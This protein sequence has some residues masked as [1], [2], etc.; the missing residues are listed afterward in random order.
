[1]RLGGAFEGKGAI[2]HGFDAP[3]RYQIERIGELRPGHT[4][5]GQDRDVAQEQLSGID[6]DEFAG[7]LACQNDAPVIGHAAA[8]RLEYRATDVIDDDVDAPTIS[9]ATDPAPET[10]SPLDNDH[11]VA[12]PLANLPRLLRCR[13]NRVHQLARH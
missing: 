7:E 13:R 12:A 6:R 3:A 5:G 9:N 2:D 8:C 1:M 10:L 4:F 11:F